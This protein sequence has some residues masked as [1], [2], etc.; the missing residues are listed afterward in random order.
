MPSS[1]GDTVQEDLRGYRGLR[2][3]AALWYGVNGVVL[4]VQGLHEAIEQ[5][6]GVSEVS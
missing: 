5:W 3:V 4:Y 2:P 1:W 6:I